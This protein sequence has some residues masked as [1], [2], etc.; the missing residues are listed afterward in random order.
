MVPMILQAPGRSVAS[1]VA[2]YLHDCATRADRR[3]LASAAI[4]ASLVD[5]SER[6][7]GGCDMVYT[8]G[9]VHMCLCAYL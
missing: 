3:V 9:W 4:I 2:S 7:L 1:A 8:Q 6:R 5:V